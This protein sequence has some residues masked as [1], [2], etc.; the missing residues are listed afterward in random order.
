MDSPRYP[1][2]RADEAVALVHQLRDAGHQNVGFLCDFY[3]LAMEGADLLGVVD[4]YGS[5]IEH[6]QVADAPGRHEPGT[7][8]VDFDTVLPHL[9]TSGYAGWVGC[10]YRPSGMSSESFGWMDRF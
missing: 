1:L 4:T 5:Y 2:T 7:G 9:R 3:H 8:T 10:E 6:V